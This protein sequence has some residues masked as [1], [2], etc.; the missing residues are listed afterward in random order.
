MKPEPQ[1]FFLRLIYCYSNQQFSVFYV[2][3]FFHGFVMVGGWHQVA[4]LGTAPA[5]IHQNKCL[6]YNNKHLLDEVFVISRI[7]KVEVTHL[8]EETLII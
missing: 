7:V 2:V 8:L 5:A 4:A 6:P 1:V 3:T